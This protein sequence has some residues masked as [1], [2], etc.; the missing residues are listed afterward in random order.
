LLKQQK[1]EAVYRIAHP[2]WKHCGQPAKARQAPNWRGAAAL[3]C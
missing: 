1:E 3:A 2:G